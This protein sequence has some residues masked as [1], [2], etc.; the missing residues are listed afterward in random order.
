MRTQ[1]QKYIFIILLLFI[2]S[3]ISYDCGHSIGYNDG[4]FEG[5]IDGHINNKYI[6][7][8]YANFSAENATKEKLRWESIRGMNLSESDRFLKENG[9]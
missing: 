1:L 2:S 9:E 8:D 7:H 5:Y 4:Y 6:T 3:Y